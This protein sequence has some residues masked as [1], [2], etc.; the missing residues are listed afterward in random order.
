[1]AGWAAHFA[2]RRRM[3]RAAAKIHQGRLASYSDG[4]TKDN[5]ENYSQCITKNAEAPQYSIFSYNIYN[6]FYRNIRDEMIAD[7]ILLCF[8]S[9]FTS[10][11]WR[12]V[13]MAFLHA[14]M[15]R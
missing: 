5:R 15:R 1:M 6:G 12:Q 14:S 9:A 13:K 7:V 11:R 2:T 4:M 8:C 3:T 10:P